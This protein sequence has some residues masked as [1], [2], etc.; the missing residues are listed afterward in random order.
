MSPG[1]REVLRFALAARVGRLGLEAALEVGPAPLVLVGP[2][3]AGKSSLL[4]L[5]LGLLPAD[6]GRVALGE[7][8]LYDAQAGVDVPTERRALGYVP[9]EY[10]LFPH[11]TALGN[12]EFAVGAHHPELSRA[13]RRERARACLAQLDAAGLEARRPAALSGGEKQKVALA[14][15]V[16]GEPRALLLDEPLA[17]LDAVARAQV[18]AFLAAR[19]EALGLPALI[20]THDPADAA[21]LGGRVAV[22]EEGRLVQSGSLAELRA[23]PATEFVARFAGTAPEAAR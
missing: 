16:A 7:T 15:A 13:A 18:R 19:L 6:S 21:A 4:L 23:H 9:Q 20:V 22:L 1:A 12:V 3:G 11:L 2:N 5:L 17:A 10:A 14:R 8:V